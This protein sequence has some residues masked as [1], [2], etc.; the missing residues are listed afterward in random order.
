L[1]VIVIT[2]MLRYGPCVT[3][4]SHSFRY[5]PPTHEPWRLQPQGITALWLVLIAATHEGMARLSC[6]GGW[7]QTE[8]NVPHWELY[9]DTVTHPS[10]NQARCTFHWSRPMRSRYRYAKPPP[11][12]QVPV[13]AG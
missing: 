4:G 6:L 13:P 2:K 8:I 3:M 10:T 12:C 9:P 7:L 11:W 5:L 1:I